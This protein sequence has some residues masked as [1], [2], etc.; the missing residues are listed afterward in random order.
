MH[1]NN[2]TWWRVEAAHYNERFSE[3][4]SLIQYVQAPNV[5]E[6]T[7]LGRAKM[8]EQYASLRNAWDII[9]VT[10]KRPFITPHTPSGT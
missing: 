5:E 3:W 10:C 8:H 2:T 7:R 1:L 4:L 6:A 9:S